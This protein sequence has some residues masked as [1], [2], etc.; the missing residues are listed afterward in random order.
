M[1]SK[2]F[3]FKTIPFL[4]LTL[5]TGA[6]DTKAS[7]YDIFYKL[8]TGGTLNPAPVG[9]LPPGNYPYSAAA[10]VSGTNW[11]QV[12]RNTTLNLTGLAVGTYPYSA[13]NQ[14]AGGLV[15]DAAS[16]TLSG[17]TL[18]ITYT[19]NSASNTRAEPSTGSGENTIQPGGVMQ[20]SFRGYLGGGCGFI[21]TFSGLPAA[22][23]FDLYVY[24]GTGSGAGLSLSLLP[25]YVLGLNTNNAIL[26]NGLAN[27]AGAYG[28]IWTGTSPNYTLLA[29]SNSWRVLHG[30]T[31]SSGNF[32]FKHNGGS[33]SGSSSSYFSGFQLVQIPFSTYS[34]T[35]GGSDCTSVTVG[36]NGSQTGV[37]YQLMNGSTNVGSPVPGTGSAISFG[38][39]TS[40]GTYT[41]VGTMTDGTS[42]GGSATMTGSAVVTIN[43]ATSVGA[44]SPASQ[45]T[46]VGATINI[47]VTSDGTAPLTCVWQKG[48][49]I[50]TNGLQT[51][52]ST[53]LGVDTTNLQIADVQLGDAAST[54]Q[55]YTCTVS[56]GCGSPV[57]SAEATLSVT[58]SDTPPI[59]GSLTNQTVVAGN[60]ATLSVNIL[61]GY[62]IPGLQWYLS[63][64]GGATSNGIAG[65]TNSTLVLTNVQYS[66]N[67]YQYSVEATN[68]A[69]TAVSNM[70]LTVVVPVTISSQPTN[71]VVFNGSSA[72]FS[73]TASGV[74]T[75]SFQ[76]YF[77]TNSSA[78]N[79]P[80]IGATG[81]N[82]TIASATPANIGGYFVIASN[83]VNS[84][85]SS[86][87]TLKVNSTTMSVASLAPSNS[88]VNICYDTPLYITFNQTPVLEKTGKIRIYNVTNSVTPVETIDLSLNTNGVQ[89]RSLFSGD[90]T[91][92]NYYPVVV[93]GTTA[94]IYLH[95]A[96]GL[97]TSNQTYYVTVDDGV[98]ADTTGAYFAGITATNVWQFATKVGGPVDPANPVVNVDG[99]GDFVTV[100]GA[101]DSLALNA[102]GVRRTIRIMNGTYYELVN[103]SGKT[104]LTLL[105]QNRYATIIKYPNNSGIGANSGAVA[106]R[107]SFKINGN[108][109]ALDNLTLTNSTPQGGGQAEALNTAGNRTIV[110]NCDVGSRQDTLLP[111]QVFFYNSKIYGNFDYIWGG[112]TLYFYKCVF[113][114]VT[115]AQNLT[116]ARTATSISLSASTPWINPNRTTYSANGFSF[117]DCLFEADPG[118]T[119]VTLADSNGSSGGLDCWAFCQFDTSAY[120]AP[121]YSL[122]TN[123]VFWQYQNT[124]T[125]GNPASFANVQTI[126]VTNNDPRL[127][128]VTNVTTWLNGWTPQLLPNIT[129]NPVA[130]TVNQGQ[131]ANF[132]VS[133]TGIPDP[134]YQW[135]SNG[136]P[137]IGAMNATLAISNVQFSD[138][139]SYSVVVSN[140][141]GTVTS[142]NATLT[143]PD[144]P[145]VANP[146]TYMRPAGQPLNILISSLAAADWSDPDGDALSLTGAISST[147]SATVAYDGT[148]LHYTNANDVADDIG[149]TITD[150]HGG[151]T[152]GLINLLIG[153][154]PTNVVSSAVNNGNGTIT[155]NFLGAPNYL[156]QIETAADLAPPVTWT[157]ISTNMADDGGVW[158]F[159]D[160]TTNYPQRFYRSVYRP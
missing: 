3:C 32:A 48:G 30:Q 53:I 85:T 20:Y 97:L 155:L 138:A 68:D 27:S 14:A 91:L 33:F 65:A 99:S 49:V 130:Q 135:L 102:N 104:N 145:P 37:S 56:G 22:T 11:N 127:L 153:P 64:D 131:T 120:I 47:S 109:V 66:Q 108:D 19:N 149:Y 5:L 63:T 136:V 46:T 89:A 160:A 142:S 137:I 41:V 18:A 128:A 144:R 42:L 103:I 43:P 117:V 79:S 61:S 72:S 151:N 134:S 88:A 25:G 7:L 8:N 15:V 28:S 51:S 157:P 29:Q 119:G 21:Y 105:G 154:P 121:S 12:S 40:S 152:G 126:G 132:A 133:A 122:S 26:L 125:N 17:V 70:V 116:A 141:A 156:Y 74:P 59:L 54:G 86:V 95:S 115:G 38:G 114:T 71:Q 106:G 159:T 80:I 4:C 23:P 34:V 83:S 6:I 90:S 101:A 73:V 87:A 123:Y 9:I 45:I 1:S 36:L 147:N 50:L 16:N 52:G 92:F 93:T 57:T 113:H 77:A 112:G 110:N 24:T 98:F 100:Q 31:D 148:Y 118:L 143:V 146:A 158:Q 129:T 84:V 44:A 96:S 111:G 13:N 60:N 94:A 55:G 124:D 150:G 2:S 81:T 78:A 76:W 35:G 75:P 58:S 140:A 107:C 62:P 67:N 69:G 82:Y 39:Q 139:G 10:P